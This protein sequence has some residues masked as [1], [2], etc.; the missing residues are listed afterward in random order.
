MNRFGGIRFYAYNII[1][2]M[3]LEIALDVN[4]DWTNR[5]PTPQVKVEIELLKTQ[6]IFPENR[7]FSVKAAL[8]FGIKPLRVS[9]NGMWIYGKP[10]P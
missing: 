4:R 2:Y 10:F 7:I 5:G 3:R 1:K 6:S 9:W 8:G